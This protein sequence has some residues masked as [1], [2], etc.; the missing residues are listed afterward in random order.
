MQPHEGSK[1]DFNSLVSIFCVLKQTRDMS[2]IPH[3][4][5]RMLIVNGGDFDTLTKCRWAADKED[6]G[7]WVKLNPPDKLLAL[8]APLP[9]PHPQA[10]PPGKLVLKRRYACKVVALVSPVTFQHTTQLL[11]ES[12]RLGPKGQLSAM[13]QKYSVASGRVWRKDTEQQHEESTDVFHSFS[14]NLCRQRIRRR[15]DNFHLERTHWGM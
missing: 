2:H 1:R 15:T 8:S 13:C 6:D 10:L 3:N 12:P 5:S 14:V 7:R 4:T 9:P 11:P